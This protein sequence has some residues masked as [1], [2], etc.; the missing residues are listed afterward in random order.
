MIKY[1]LWTHTQTQKK[2]KKAWKGF[3]SLPLAYCDG[4]N[5]FYNTD[6]FINLNTHLRGLS[7]YFNLIKKLCL[8][9]KDLI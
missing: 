2:F 3:L 4:K 8:A 6:V 9:R 7:L 5:K 1:V